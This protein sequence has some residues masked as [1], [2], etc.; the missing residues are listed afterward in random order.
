[1]AAPTPS[2]QQ[3]QPCILSTLKSLQSADSQHDSKKP[4]G[5]SSPG[6]LGPKA[7]PQRMPL[8]RTMFP[9]PARHR[10][11]ASPVTVHAQHLQTLLAHSGWLSRSGC[12]GSLT[13]HK[14]PGNGSTGHGS[15]GHILHFEEQRRKYVLFAEDGRQ[16]RCSGWAVAAWWDR[17]LYLIQHQQP[18]LPWGPSLW[19]PH[20]P[21]SHISSSTAAW[22]RAQLLR[23]LQPGLAG[24][25]ICRS[26]PP[27]P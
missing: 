25:R 9:V 14:L 12:T 16:I 5:T 24:L 8:A 3:Y 21:W 11:G 2:Q 27:S 1:M 10:R 13:F 26:S 6:Q 19:E 23:H 7:T 20:P 22:Q 17:I 4:Q 15:I 18:P